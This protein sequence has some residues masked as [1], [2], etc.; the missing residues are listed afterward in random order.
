MIWS[1]WFTSLGPPLF[2]WVML[3]GMV[4]GL[5]LAI[6]AAVRRRVAMATV[7]LLLAAVIGLAI[8]YFGSTN[9]FCVAPPGSACA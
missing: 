5:L 1:S 2:F 3:A 4:V 9:G 6:V 8:M 7:W